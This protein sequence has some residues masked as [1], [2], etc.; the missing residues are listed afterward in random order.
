VLYRT[1]ATGAS[2]L[3][4]FSYQITPVDGRGLRP[5]VTIRQGESLYEPPERRLA[6]L[7]SGGNPGSAPIAK[8]EDVDLAYDRTNQVYFITVR[9]DPDTRWVAEPGQLL[10][11]AERENPSSVTNR[12]TGSDLAVRVLRKTKLANG[13][14]RADLDRAPRAEGESFLEDIDSVEAVKVW[15][16]Q[17]TV[18]NTRG[19]STWKLSPLDYRVI[20]VR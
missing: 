11:I 7:G 14:I 8:V 16:V 9:D 12:R 6:I 1:F 18:K 5:S 2:Q 10:V 20:Q 17:E 4:I 15:A 3:G 13:D 19:G